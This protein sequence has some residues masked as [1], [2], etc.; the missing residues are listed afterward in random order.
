MAAA[1]LALALTPAAAAG[2]DD[3]AACGDELSTAGDGS[4]EGNA[5]TTGVEVSTE[6]AVAGATT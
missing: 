1:M 5:S 4:T 6:S 2:T 3:R